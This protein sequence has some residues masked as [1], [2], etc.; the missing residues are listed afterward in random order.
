MNI[1]QKPPVP[2]MTVDEFFAWDGGGHQGKLELVEGVVR[3]MAPAS[4]AH[5]FIQA[6]IGGMIREQLRARKSLC[7]VGTE[8]GVIPPLHQKKNARVPDI[9]VTCAPPSTSKVFESPVLI[10]EVISPSN[11]DETWDS[12]TALAGLV[13]LKE[14][15]VVQSERVEA[16]VYT[17]ED[18]GAWPRDPVKVG[19][20]GVV[21]LK[22]IG[23]EL[24]MGEVYEGTV[25]VG[26]TGDAT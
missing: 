1:Q 8:A 24:D 19:A 5:S 17:R 13:S 15:L 22:S 20:G 23:C 14:I 7:R 21:R 6:N 11:E 3:A 18:D 9:A 4:P 12:I 10:V 25:L 2:P 16:E 26:G